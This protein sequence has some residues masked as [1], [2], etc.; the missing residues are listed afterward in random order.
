MPFQLSLFK[1]H[2]ALHLLLPAG[3]FVTLFWLLL[4]NEYNSVNQGLNEKNVLDGTNQIQL[5]TQSLNKEMNAV[6]NEVQRVAY[7]TPLTNYLTTPNTQNKE[8]LEADWLALVKY[9]SNIQQVRYLDSTGFEK[10]RVSRDAIGEQPMVPTQ[11]QNKI[12]R[13]YVQ[14]SLNMIPNTLAITPFDLNQE[15]GQIQQ[16]IMPTIRFIYKLDYADYKSGILVINYYA[17]SVFTDIAKLADSRLNIINHEGF[18]L[19]GQNAWS[20]LLDGIGSLKEQNPQKWAELQNL[21]SG[22]LEQKNQSII[23]KLSFAHLAPNAKPIYLS[24]EL[25]LYTLSITQI[26]GDIWFWIVLFSSLLFLSMVF[27]I[28][29][30]LTAL[31]AQTLRAQ[32]SEEAAKQALAVKSTFLANMSHEIRTP[33]N[34]IM[35]FFQLLVN[36]PLSVRQLRYAKEG[37]N[38]TK[39]LTQIIN[40]ILDFSKLEVQKMQLNH[41]RFSLDELVREVGVLMTA[42]LENKP[43]DIWFDID[44]SLST[45]FLGDDVRLKQILVNL[46]NN[47]IKFTHE[48]FI[49]IRITRIAN[50]QNS[51]TI[52]F[53]IADSGIGLSG[54][55]IHRI[56]DSFEQADKRISKDFGGT[57][58]GLSISKGLLELMDSEL[59]VVSTVGIGSTF[60]FEVKLKHA[61]D[62][63]TRRDRF[64]ALS[65]SIP[66]MKNLHFL[67]VC[68]SGIGAEFLERMCH[69]FSWSTVTSSAPSDAAKAMF[70]SFDS[71]PFDIVMIDKKLA[72]M[73]DWALVKHLK[74]L[75][76]NHNMPLFFMVVTLNTELND[77]YEKQELL[78]LDGHFIKPITPST[79]FDTIS[80]VMRKVKLEDMPVLPKTFKADLSG[81]H[82]L[83]VEDNF[84]NQEVV[85]NMMQQLNAIVTVLDNGQQAVDELSKGDCKYDLILMDMQMPV[86]D[87]VSATKLIRDIPY[88]SKIPI[89]ALTANAQESDKQTCLQAGMDDHLAKPFDQV[90]LSTIITEYAVMSHNKESK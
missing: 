90:Q 36:E 57:G 16:P 65:D 88:C 76:E 45:H 23:T 75:C 31:H 72:A 24:F 55:Q 62:A 34:G 53:S 39:L 12:A 28:S 59:K 46:T 25:P 4:Y 7:S 73:N 83:L 49:I 68:Q 84:I 22:Q 66:D 70:N 50:S 41:T 43:L 47:A 48:G 40:D 29:K 80:R 2:S 11:M 14:S 78:L 58:L 21:K 42:N 51:S 9:R 1:R 82:I 27:Y 86:M 71:K 69:Q 52:E 5:V 37:F 33:L 67:L 81:L 54:E 60:S 87:G 30:S 32:A 15:F 10:I 13:D 18:Y 74:Q 17:E 89:I 20:W 77:A 8:Q 64:V 61:G 44:E 26:M 85:V 38:T 79:L 63:D 19:N 3:I 56:F 6:S 35:G